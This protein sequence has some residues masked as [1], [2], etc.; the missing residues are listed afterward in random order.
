[1]LAHLLI[2]PRGL[3]FPMPTRKIATS[4]NEIGEGIDRVLL[5]VGVWGSSDKL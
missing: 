5:R 2:S 4:G 3:D 1:M